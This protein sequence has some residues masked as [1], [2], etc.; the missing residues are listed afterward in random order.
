MEAFRTD[1]LSKCKEQSVEPQPALLNT[2]SKIQSQN[3]IHAKLDLSGHALSIKEISCIAYAL[4]KDVI[5]TKLVFSDSF[6][7]DDGCI[8][9]ANAL[10][11]NTTAT[12][13]DLRGNSIRSEGAIALG[14]M[15]KVN[16]A[17]KKYF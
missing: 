8:I 16:G 9:L 2:L 15:L 10:K 13:L 1:Y 14:Q 17:L 6:M 7:G 5:F 12:L 11:T 4:A 3:L